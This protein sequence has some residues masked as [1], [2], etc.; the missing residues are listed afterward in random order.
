MSPRFELRRVVRRYL[1]RDRPNEWLAALDG[2]DLVL[3]EH[4]VTALV[5]PSGAGKS[6]LARVLLRLEGIDAGEL[7]YGGLPVQ[8]CNRRE[9]RL[10]NGIMFQNPLLA[11]NPAFT[12]ER[13]VS[14]PLRANGFTRSEA[15]H[16]TAG[17]LAS[18]ELPSRLSDRYPA[19]LSTGQLQRV[20]LARALA[21]E[22]EFL[23]LDEPF[24]CL[25]EI[26]ASRLLRLLVRQQ[27]EHGLGLL[28]ICH[29]P[30]HTVA[31]AQRTV[32]MRAGQITDIHEN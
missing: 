23:A 2:V 7:L 24:S 17:L 13:I 16:R 12:V 6:T 28:L 32:T 19:E 25:D 27:R 9:F 20:A 29:N 5:G 11:V 31:L 30:R 21:L 14:E 8:T 18:M 22:P 4:V 15:R 3:P 1:R 26:A 10:R